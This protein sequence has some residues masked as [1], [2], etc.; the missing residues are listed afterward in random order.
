MYT[1]ILCK[2][3]IRRRWNSRR[4]NSPF[5]IIFLKIT[6]AI[7]PGIPGRLWK[8]RIRDVRF[9]GDPFFCVAHLASNATVLIQCS[10][11]SVMHLALDASLDRVINIDDSRGFKDKSKVRTDELVLNWFI[12][13][14]IICEYN[15]VSRYYL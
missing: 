2:R 5:I 13:P 11:Q 8:A 6:E 9:S 3:R 15:I 10:I 12:I 14:S 4:R 1:Y 7:P